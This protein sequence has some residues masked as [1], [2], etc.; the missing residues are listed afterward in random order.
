VLVALVK[1][2]S[3]I[4]SPCLKICA[5]NNGKC[6]GCNRTK[7]EIREWFYATDER[8]LEILNRILNE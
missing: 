7:E 3:N 1:S 5:I 6:I 4:I 8:K 2:I